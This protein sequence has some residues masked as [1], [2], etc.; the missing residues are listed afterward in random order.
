MP[1][2]DGFEIYNRFYP[3][4]QRFRLG[5]PVLVREVTGMEWPQFTQALAEMD[6]E[7]AVAVAEGRQDEFVPDQVVLLG[8]IA[9]AFW[10]GNQTMTRAKVAREVQ[11]IPIDKVQFVAGESEE[12][13]GRPPAEAAAGEPQRATSSASDGSP[14]GNHR[15]ETPQDSISDETSL[16]ASGSPGSPSPHPE[17]LPA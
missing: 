13:D 2:Q 7:F 9:V 1:D 14:E 6:E 17:S 4:P 11:K 10:Q 8:L 3:A 16:S 12:D 5:D 15:T